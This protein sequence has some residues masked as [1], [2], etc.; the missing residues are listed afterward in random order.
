MCVRS[1]C[2]VCSACLCVV[3]ALC[4]LNM[5]MLLDVVHV[6]I[7]CLVCAGRVG[8]KGGKREGYHL[9]ICTN[10][11]EVEASVTALRAPMVVV[12]GVWVWV[13]VC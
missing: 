9:R 10:S 8:N 2:L 11:G 5:L 6:L 4:V 1:A 3:R 13:W 12:V 7:A